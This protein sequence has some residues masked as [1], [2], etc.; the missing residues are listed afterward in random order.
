MLTYADICC[1]VVWSLQEA[2]AVYDEVS[3]EAGQRDVVGYITGLLLV[4]VVRGT[5]D[6]CCEVS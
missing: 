5:L 2:Q 3:I 1:R 4:D 6:A